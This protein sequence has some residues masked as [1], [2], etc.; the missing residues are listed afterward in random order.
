MTT[1]YDVDQ[2][3]ELLKNRIDQLFEIESE[4]NQRKGIPDTMGAVM[5]GEFSDVR[6]HIWLDGDHVVIIGKASNFYKIYLDR[7]GHK[8]RLYH[9]SQVDEDAYKLHALRYGAWVQRFD[10]YV[11]H[12]QKQCDADDPELNN[13]DANAFRP[14]DF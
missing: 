8:T 5:W 6:K 13:N 12:L 11:E 14:I 7:H 10:E 3:T 4:L 2:T 9:L 1:D